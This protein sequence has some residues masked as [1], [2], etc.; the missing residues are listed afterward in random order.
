[1]GTEQTNKE[2]TYIIIFKYAEEIK[3]LERNKPDSYIQEIFALF[4]SYVK[5]EDFIPIILISNFCF[6]FFC[7]TVT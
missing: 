5:S 2:I 1:M 7:N 4:L 3:K 6:C